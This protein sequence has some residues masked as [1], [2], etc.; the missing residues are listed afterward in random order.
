MRKLLVIALLLAS[1]PGAAAASDEPPTAATPAP[2][3]EHAREDEHDARG[4][5]GGR[6]GLLRRRPR[7][8]GPTTAG[9]VEA[10]YHQPPKPAEA[11]LG[12]TITLTGTN[13][14]V[15]LRRDGDRRRSGS[16]TT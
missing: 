7:A 3:G 2:D 14:G 10:E 12:E 15:R 6:Q 16:T 13:I 8:R 5:L 11:E 1:S 4:L 9:N